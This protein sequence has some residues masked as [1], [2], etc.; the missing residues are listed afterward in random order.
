MT[1]Y[2]MGIDP[3]TPNLRTPSST[4]RPPPHRTKVPTAGLAAQDA[5][6]DLVDRIVAPSHTED[7]WLPC[8]SR[9]SAVPDSRSGPHSMAAYSSPWKVGPKR[10]PVLAS[11]PR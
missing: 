9:Y 8:P 5:A 3:G 10:E 1:T 4:D 7:L 11:A 6:Q 2:V